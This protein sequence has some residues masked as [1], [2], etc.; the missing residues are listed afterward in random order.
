MD[1]TQLSGKKIKIGF[2]GVDRKKSIGGGGEIWAKRKFFWLS[3]S[4]PPLEATREG[5]KFKL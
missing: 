3:S 5:A 4:P 1:T 2:K